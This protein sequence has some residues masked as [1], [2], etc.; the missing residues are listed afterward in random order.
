MKGKKITILLLLLLSAVLVFYLTKQEPPAEGPPG[1]ENAQPGPPGEDIIAEIMREMTL[2]EK[3]GQLLM[4][5]FQFDSEG[6]PVKAVTKEIRE[7][8]AQFQVGGVILFSPN[9]ESVEQT[10]ALIAELQAA[11]KI[12]LFIAVDEEGGKVSRLNH[13]G[14]RIGATKLPGNAALGNTHDPELAYQ[15]GR[16]LGRELFV[17]GFNM[18]MAPV[19]DVNTNPDNPVIG[20]RAFGGDPRE[21]AQMVGR[22][23]QG[24]Q[25][26]NVSSVIKHFPGHGDTALDT[27][28]GAVVLDH[29]RERLEKVEWMPFRQGIAAGV[30]GIMVAHLI[31]PQVS[32]SELPASLSTEMLTGVLREEMQYKGLII[33]DALDMAAI[34][35]HFSAG[36]AAVLAAAAGADILLMPESL[37]AA[38]QALLAAVKEG[39]LGKEQLDASV[40]RILQTK[41][42]RGLLDGAADRP[43]PYAVLGSEEHQNIVEE[44]LVRQM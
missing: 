35:D 36:E 16:L 43:D 5:S 12:P 44:I 6:K 39:R 19:A 27:H 21:V 4:P 32:G 15:V 8:L 31:V 42:K 1:G 9:I 34:T 41:K 25:S 17:L 20:E 37:P 24:L 26:E 13:D 28:Q 10:R 11:S 30:D 3:I 29:G 7:Q 38:Y 33:T 2:E 18:D 40:R 23:V 14:S 22:M